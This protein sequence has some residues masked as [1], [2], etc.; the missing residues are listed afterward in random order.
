MTRLQAEAAVGASLG[1]DGNDNWQDCDYMPAHGLPSGVS[2]MVEAGTIARVDVDTNVVATAEGAHIGDSEDRILQ[3]YRG[4]VVTTPHKY[5]DGHYLT[6]RSAG[7][8]SL[9]GIVFETDHGRVT[10][11]HAGR[12]PPVAYVEGCE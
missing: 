10:L 4:R 9:Y 5:T 3:L 11:Y 12:F 8:D 7:A 6:V 1:I 2:V